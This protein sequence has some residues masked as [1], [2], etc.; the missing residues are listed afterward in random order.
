MLRL[1]QLLL[2]ICV[3][4]GR[5]MKCWIDVSISI[6]LEASGVNVNAFGL[7]IVAGV[8]VTAGFIDGGDV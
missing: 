6:S 4:S 2:K 8:D 5:Q 7:D 1:E 3:N